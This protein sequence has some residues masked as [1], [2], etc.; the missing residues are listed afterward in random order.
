MTFTIDAV[1][2]DTEPFSFSYSW[3]D[4]VL[5]ALGVG[6]KASELDYLYEGRGPKVLPSFAVIPAFEP[7]MKAIERINGP[8]DKV[9][10]GTQRV[11]IHKPFAPKAT[12]LTT[13]RVEGLFDLKRMTQTTVTTQTRDA[14][15]N[16]LV[17]ET[18]WGILFLGIGG[19]NTGDRVQEEKP[20][21]PSRP[22]D[23]TIEEK[24]LPEQA[25]LY[26]LSGDI[27]PLHADPEFPLVSRF[28]GKPILHGL[29]T[30][31][32]M[33]RAVVHGALNGDSSK[34]KA[35]QG[36]FSKPVW[37]G[38]TLVTEGWTEGSRVFARTSVKER[39]EVVLSHCAI[40][41]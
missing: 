12:L 27:N 19:V 38:E 31:G 5:Y 16:E 28:E 23:F 41:L 7:V 4:A 39:N 3:K 33:C 30:Y 17:C 10:H 6:A 15:S 36:R 8:M 20:S 35:I 22:A 34:V 18:S 37:P 14:E 1:R 26:R 25:L 40:D 32:Y 29:A 11:K 24:T 9:V 21:P 2:K 13:A